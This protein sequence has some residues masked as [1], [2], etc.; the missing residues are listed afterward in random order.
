MLAEN[1]DQ[2]APDRLVR[3]PLREA[4]RAARANHTVNGYAGAGSSHG[5]I[6]LSGGAAVW[7]YAAGSCRRP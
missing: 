1:E 3:G 4:V 2:G 5:S 7:D 6:S